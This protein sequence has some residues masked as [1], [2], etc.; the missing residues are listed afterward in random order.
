MALEQ[1]SGV[2]DRA[3]ALAPHRAICLP[4][5]V[6]NQPFVLP[7]TTGSAR[8]GDYVSADLTQSMLGLTSVSGA[9]ALSSVIARRGSIERQGYRIG[10]I[11]LL[12]GYDGASE[13]TE[14]LPVHRLPGVPSW[15]RGVA[16]LHGN[17]IPVFELSAMLGTSHGT[18]TPMLLVLGHA[19]L[20][21]AV[22]I[23]GLPERKRFA[24]EDKI[25]SAVVPD[26][27]DGYVKA[28]YSS[29]DK[30]HEVWLDFDHMRFLDELSTRPS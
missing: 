4:S 21:A 18:E 6:L 10:N 19:E 8:P 15:V 23:D 27:I 24:L 1:G 20:A 9:T 3:G 13:L 2:D 12:T 26:A 14:M 7:D 25:E 17:V 22:V 28:A 16:N 30:P 11:L 5:E 29:L